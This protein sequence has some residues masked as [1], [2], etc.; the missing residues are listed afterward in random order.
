MAVGHNDRNEIIKKFCGTK[1]GIKRLQSN[2]EPQ[3]L[4]HKRAGQQQ[5]YRN[6]SLLTH[7]HHCVFYALSLLKLHSTY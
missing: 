7:F 2:Q 3:D 4:S 1:E 6:S 5:P